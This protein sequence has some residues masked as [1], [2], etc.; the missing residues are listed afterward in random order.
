MKTF[1][2]IIAV[3]ALTL[4]LG[5][6][7]GCR[8]ASDNGKIDGYWKIQ[9]ILYT[10]EGVVVNPENEFIAIQ[11]E[12]LQLQN[13]EPTPALTGILSYSKGADQMSVEFPN[14]PTEQQLAAFGFSGTHTTLHID[15]V[16]GKRMVLTSP[17]AKITCRKW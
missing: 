4:T 3:L 14:N 13:P 12:L 9:E 1:K 7:G 2:L 17:I 11:L 16:D 15:H 6:S 5:V 10:A 8:R